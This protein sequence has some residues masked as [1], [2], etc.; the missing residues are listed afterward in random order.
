MTRRAF[1]RDVRSGWTGGPAHPRPQDWESAPW[2]ILPA[3]APFGFRDLRGPLG[4]EAFV[5]L[6]FEIGH[7]DPRVR[8]LVHGSVTPSH[9]L[10][11]IR[12]VGILVRVVVPGR[13]DQGGALRE[14]R[15]CVLGVDIVDVPVP[16][17]V[18]GG[19]VA[20]RPSNAG[21]YVVT[22]I[23][24]RT[25]G[26]PLCRNDRGYQYTAWPVGPDTYRFSTP[27]AH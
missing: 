22:G 24:S 8:H 25:Q 3:T 27:Q 9:P 13:E 18:V 26:T 12:V 15:G 20:Q 21:T 5:F 2:E 17:E 23:R 11:V 16:L 19:T 1:S 4:D 6:L 10:S 7:I 14:E